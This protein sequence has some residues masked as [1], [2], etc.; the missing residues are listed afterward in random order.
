MTGKGII[1]NVKDFAPRWLVIS[2]V[3]ILV[4]ANTFNIA[5]DLAAMGEALSLVIGG[6]NHEHALIFA[7]TSV[8]LQV[9]VRYR[10]YAPALKFL[11]LVL[12]LYVATA[13]TVHIPWGEAFAR[14][15]WPAAEVNRDYLL[16]VVAVLGTTIS[17][18]LFFWHASQEVEE[19]KQN[20][21][22]R[23]LKERRPLKDL[24]RG[25]ESE[26][27][28]IA[29]DT[30]VGMAF[31]NII[32]FF[33][34]LTTAAVLNAGGVTNIHSA[35]EA[36]E[37]LRPL[38]GDL[39]FALFALGI[40]GTGLLAVP[41]LAGSAAY[42]VSEAFGWPATLEAKA[43]DAVGFYSIIAAATAVGL[44]LGYTPIDPIQMLIWSAVLNGICRGSDHGG[45]DGGRYAPFGDGSFQRPAD[46]HFLWMGWHS[47]WL[48]LLWHSSGPRLA[49]PHS[50]PEYWPRS[51][52]Y[53]ARLPSQPGGGIGPRSPAAVSHERS[54]SGRP[55]DTIG[56]FGLRGRK[57]EV[58]R[59]TI[60]SQKPRYWR[61]FLR[62]MG[63]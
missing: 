42:C 15:V 8:L 50:Q 4:M 31:S 49:E 48:L 28:R 63:E 32:A 20:Q 44:T 19:M 27:E 46:A 36:A 39:T 10:R 51:K 2:L 55:P 38:A 41:V 13:F 26:I 18:F 22:R 58:W 56:K 59:L 5:A 53:N 1:A 62:N 24:L 47:E 16:M 43:P 30:S 21:P 54:F 60:E 12:F 34:I 7:A 35:A 61:A 23:P 37:A 17:P 45:H 40:V 6:L 11:T 9:F 3:S 14:A 29:L 52:S 33:I 25:G 57:L